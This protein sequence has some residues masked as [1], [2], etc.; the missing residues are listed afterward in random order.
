MTKEKE[1]NQNNNGRYIDSLFSIPIERFDQWEAFLFLKDFSFFQQTKSD[2]KT[3]LYFSC[4]VVSLGL[5]CV[6]KNITA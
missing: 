5:F 3:F 1:K 6:K 2:S 4:L